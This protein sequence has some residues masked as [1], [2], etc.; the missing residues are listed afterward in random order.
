[1]FHAGLQQ[2]T[3]AVTLADAVYTNDALPQFMVNANTGVKVA[4]YD[5]FVC[6]WNW[7][8]CRHKV[9]VKPVLD[10]IRIGHRGL[11]YT[12]KCSVPVSWER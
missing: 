2:E 6:P 11:I 1:M 8:Y 5:E 9:F 7:F 10:F 12:N 3:V 4:V